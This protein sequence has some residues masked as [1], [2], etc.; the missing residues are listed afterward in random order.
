M[1][2][3]TNKQKTTWNIVKGITN[4]TD[5]TYDL[6]PMNINNEL[7]N[8]PTATVNALNSYFLSV[9]E[10]LLTKNF[11]SRKTNNNRD[12]LIYLKQKSNQCLSHIKLK[13]TSSSVIEKIITS[14][15]CKNSYGYDEISSRILKISAPYILSPHLHI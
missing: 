3:S 12:P 13:N 4:N 6:P 10:N 8:N 9:A 15:K 5:N 7:S 2:N 1:S 11:P 14:L